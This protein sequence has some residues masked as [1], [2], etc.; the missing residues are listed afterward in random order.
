MRDD[1]GQRA[2]QVV[3][4]Q[5][6]QIVLGRLQ[7]LH[8]HQLPADD[9]VLLAQA[10]KRAAAQE[11][12]PAIDRLGE[13]VVG[14]RFEAAVLVRLFAERGDEDHRQE[15]ARFRLDLL[16]DLVPVHLRH[17]HV[18]QDEVDRPQRQHLKRLG[19][20]AR[21]Q[22]FAEAA[23]G[24]A[25]EGSVHG[26]VI[27]DE[28]GR[29]GLHQ[30]GFGEQQLGVLVAGERG[31]VGEIAFQIFQ[32][33]HLPAQ[34]RHQPA[35]FLLE[36]DGLEGEV[37][38]HPQH[39]VVPRLFDETV[40]LALVD[41]AD[42][43]LW[44]GVAGEHD[45]GHV[46]IALAHQLEYLDSA[47]ARHVLIADHQ[48]DSGRLLENAQALVAALG[49]EDAVS[50]ALEDRR[51]RLP[52]RFLVVDDEDVLLLDRLHCERA[53]PIA[54]R[55]TVTGFCMHAASKHASRKTPV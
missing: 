43:D 31:E 26:L 10:E 52:H 19:A 55:A 33:V 29:T 44:I 28:H 7:P 11:Q 45:P 48:L 12:L 30:I 5:R 41:R 6:D 9:L 47:H 40:D 4:Q 22:H 17:H 53:F 39:R 38:R 27:D 34:R 49:L 2:A 13:K 8:F 18:E 25:D 36:L 15:F 16:A 42:D 50:L 21:F 23:D 51:E 14:A 3:H 20:R 35:V 37:D 46:R 54:A 24:S 1:P 32:E